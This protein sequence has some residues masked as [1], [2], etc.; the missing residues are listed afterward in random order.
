MYLVLLFSALWTLSFCGT[1][2]FYVVNESKNWTDAQKYCRGNFTDL[3]TIENQEQT[4]ILL[5]LVDGTQGYFWIGLRQKVQEN[6]SWIWSDGSNSTYRNWNTGEPNNGAGDYCV[7]LWNNPEYRWND[8]YCTRSYPFICYKALG[9]PLILINLKRTWREALRYC[10]DHHVDMVSVHTEKIQHWVETAVYYASTANVWMGLRHTCAQ[11]FWFWLS[12][13]TICYQ[14]WA[15]GNGTGVEDCSGGE[16]TGAV[17]SGSKKWVSLPEDQRLNFICTTSEVMSSAL[18]LVLLFSALWTP[19]FC[20]TRQF[21]VVNE[22][23]NWTDAQKHCRE[24]FTDLA[25][26]ESQEEMNALIAFLNGSGDL[27]WIGLRQDAQQ[28]TA[29][30]IWSDGSNSSYTNWYTGEPDSPVGDICV[31]LLKS[32]EYKWNDAGCKWP[33][34]FICYKGLPLILI[35]QNKT[36][37]EALSYC[38]ENHVDLV[39][40]HTEKIQHWVETAVLYASTANVW[41][42]LRH[43]CAQNFW[44][45]VSG[46]TICYQNWA[47][48][49]GTRVEY[50]SGG[51]RAGAVQSGSKQWVSLPEDQRLNFIC[52]TSEV[53]DTINH[54]RHK[55]RAALPAVTVMSSALYL[56]LLFSALWTLSFCGTRQFYVVNQNKNWTDAQNYCREKFTDLATIESREEMNAVTA[57]VNRPGGYFWIGLRQKVQQSTVSW[58]WSDGSSS[59]YRYWN[60]GE[61]NNP[62]GDNCVQLRNSPEHTWNDEGCKWPNPFICYKDLPLI[63]IKEKKTWREALRYC[64]ENYVDMVSVHTEEIQHWVETAVYYA[65]TANVWMGLRHTCAQNFWFWVSGSTICYQN[66]A[67]G[68][69]T[70]VEDCSGGERTGAVQ[71]GSKQWVSLPEDQ[72]LNFICTTSEEL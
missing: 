64:R 39:S 2:Q 62:L 50:C 63:L 44:F 19:S 1:R 32:P 49:N 25:T 58:I 67:P 21:Y 55:H 61:P 24:N 18:Y 43:T 69:G 65:S 71:S 5:A 10:R 37:R 17:Q 57:L 53:T 56:V 40:V 29:S 7:Q 11:S 8:E 12:G 9:L 31:Q 42:G 45:W 4:D 33:N 41:M 66:W 34:P 48:G 59:S 16:R 36:W 6:T 27:S 3:A 20:G 30:W 46:S 22:S 13:S 38:R 51:E 70:G 28:S 72:R 26:I 60:T 23:K 47:S 68:N 15:P 52:T 14:N 54:R 35:N